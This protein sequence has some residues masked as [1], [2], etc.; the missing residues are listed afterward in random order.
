[1]EGTED[2]MARVGLKER[3]LSAA[4]VLSAPH[5]IPFNGPEKESLSLSAQ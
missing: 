1:M 4:T 2:E 5:Y 3:I